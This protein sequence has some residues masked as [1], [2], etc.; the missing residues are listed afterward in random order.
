MIM[1]KRIK[2]ILKQIGIFF[3]VIF[4]ICFCGLETGCKK[5]TEESYHAEM[6]VEINT[7]WPNRKQLYYGSYTSKNVIAQKNVLKD[8]LSLDVDGCP[9]VSISIEFYIVSDKTGEVV[10]TVR[11]PEETK[12]FGVFYQYYE[13]KD[14]LGTWR[15]AKLAYDIYDYPQAS[16]RADNT[17]TNNYQLQR[18]SGEHLI[19][20]KSP[21]D[22]E[23]KV[24]RSDFILRLNLRGDARK[25]VELKAQDSDRYTKISVN[26]R[27]VYIMQDGLYGTR[28][29]LIG[30]YDGETEIVSP[31]YPSGYN[32]GNTAIKAYLRKADEF[33]GSVLDVIAE[34]YYL[35]SPGIY[36]V[37][38]TFIGNA[39]YCPAE[40]IC[41]IVIPDLLLSE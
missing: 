34:P 27:D 28:M 11:V 1:Q 4:L 38:Y 36:L 32:E 18:I 15:P 5:K 30:V 8:S 9:G 16:S 14:E 12:E 39:T 24:E 21:Y 26:N 17:I 31:Q 3:S 6:G 23:Y 2:F 35:D 29:P 40:Y 19:V 33:Y 37:S 13:I 22:S 25:Q 10:K 41:Y 7:Y 20:F